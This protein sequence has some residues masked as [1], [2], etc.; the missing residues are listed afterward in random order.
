MYGL[1]YHDTNHRQ[2]TMVSTVAQEPEGFS[3]KQIAQAKTAR[4]FQTKVGHPSTQDL[5]SV[6]KLNVIAS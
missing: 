1:Y 5:K 4:N 6:I 3:K 2:L